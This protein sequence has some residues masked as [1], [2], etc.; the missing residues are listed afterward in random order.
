MAIIR[1]E[2]GPARV[3]RATSRRGLRIREG[4]IGTGFAQPKTKLNLLRINTIRGTIIVPNKS[5]CFMGLKLSRPSCSAVRSPHNE[6]TQACDASWMVMASRTGIIQMAICC[7]V[8]NS[9][10]GR[11]EKKGRESVTRK[12]GRINRLAI[13]KLLKYNQPSIIIR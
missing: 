7:I 11:A 6:A 13:L 8:D 10:M 3:T 4:V 12:M 2:R 5:M 1:L 9:G